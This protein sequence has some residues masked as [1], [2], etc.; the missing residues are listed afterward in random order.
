MSRTTSQSSCQAAD[1]FLAEQQERIYKS[2]DRL[3][4]ALMTFQ[5]AFCILLSLVISPTTWTGARSSVNP[6]VWSA[7]ILG[8]II[9]S[10]PMYLGIRHPGWVVTR[11]VVAVSQ[12]LMSAL[13]IDLTGGRI[14][15]HFHVFGSLAFLAFYRDWRV[16]IPASVV[17][18]VDHYLRGVYIPMSVFGVP[19][20]SPWRVLEHAGWVVFEDVF[21]FISCLRS[22]REMRT[23]AESTADLNRANLALRDEIAERQ[24]VEVAL[25]EVGLRNQQLAVA[26]DNAPVGVLISDARAADDPAIFVNPAF[27]EMTGY[28]GEEAL[29][30]NCRFLQ[31]E[32]TDAAMRAAIRDAVDQRKPFAGTLLNFR[33]DGTPFWN[34]LRISPVFD[35]EGEVIN[36]I[37]LQSDVT[38]RVEA[39]AALAKSEERYR[40]VVNSIYEVIFQTDR[41]G[42][43]TF[44]N[45]AWTYL[46]GRPVEESLGKR[47]LESVY[48]DDRE[49]QADS[50]RSLLSGEQEY[51]RYEIR[52]LGREDKV[53]WAEVFVRPILDS[54]GEV[55][56]AT[57]TLMDITERKLA[58]AAMQAAR[59]EAEAAN[60]AKSEFLS[61]MSHELRTPLNAILGFGQLLERRHL[62]EPQRDWVRHI[63]TAGQHLLA[64]IN[65]ILDLSRIESGRLQLSVEPICVG[66]VLREVQDLVRPLAVDA[67]V[68]LSEVEPSLYEQFIMADHQRLKQ[69]L[70]NL[71]SN[72]IKYNKDGGEVEVTGRIMPQENGRPEQFR[73]SVR[74]TGDGIPAEQISRLFTP[75][76]RLEAEQTGIPGTG[77]GLALT[78]LLL[79]AM[80]GTVGVETEPGQGSVFW[81]ELPS[82]KDPMSRF[83]EAT[84]N[85]AH[86][87]LFDTSKKLLYIED[88]LSNLKLIEHVLEAREDIQLVTA[89]RGRL[90]LD[91]A[92]QHQPDL[93]LL[94]LHLPDIMGWDI[95][96]ELHQGSGT[97]DI[98]V[99]VVSADATPSQI[100][101]LHAAGANHYLTKPIDVDE[102]LQVL[103]EVLQ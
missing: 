19:W 51:R 48:P 9:S 99:V 46:T 7:L 15:T 36:F 65:E 17:V 1:E 14:E 23:I 76:D 10:F 54:N 28:S 78:R 68:H 82:C 94:D 100:S 64:L 61:R 103:E 24:A 2:T 70:L 75:F 30:R 55:Q 45:I 22:Q 6:H 58:E 26:I 42:R 74:D 35:A 34:E 60:R 47:F 88:N 93:I 91:L 20:A 101:R 27:V 63:V 97:R 43:W 5:W 77:L 73:V 96:S 21:L 50:F 71:L 33:K 53:C 40:S 69:V 89:T 18:L 11:H 67:N 95:L 52:Y 92:R 32:G 44:L 37:G 16:L 83:A 4:V 98:P 12:M 90:G 66:E 62:Q 8:G 57:G 79:E 29:G 59:E 85:G 13:L 3:F 80:S 38:A 25:R 86:E 81:F 84:E 39:E 49:Y 87:H 72:A 31:G 41:E 56:G 102:F